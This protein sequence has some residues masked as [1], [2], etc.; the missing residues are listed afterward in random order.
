MP[1]YIK[2]MCLRELNTE[3]LA[4]L[5]DAT[6]LIDQLRKELKVSQAGNDRP[7]SEVSESGEAVDNQHGHELID[8]PPIDDQTSSI[9]VHTEEVAEEGERPNE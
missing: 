9:G 6:T 3:L 8:N 7:R 5:K 4:R 2:A 1:D